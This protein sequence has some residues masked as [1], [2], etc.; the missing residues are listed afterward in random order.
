MVACG[1]PV[2]FC[3]GAAAFLTG[4]ATGIG[5][6]MLVQR[7]SS[8]IQL[9][10]LIAIPLFILAGGI[11]AR[12]GVAKRIVDF[13]YVLVG[14]FRGGLAMVN[15]IQSMFFGGVSGSAIADIS[16]TGPIMIPM[17]VQK[18]YDR[19][20]ST[21]ITVASA[22]QGIIIPPSHNMVIYAMVAGGVS[23]GKLFL[24]GYIPGIL[25]GFALMITCYYIA[26]KRGYPS[27]KRPPLRQSMVIVRDGLLAIMAA[28][29]IVG[30]IAFGIFTVSEAS[31]IAVFYAAFLGVVVYREMGLKDIWP[32][33]IDSVKTTSSV[34]FLIG[35]ASAFAW[36]MTFL[37][38]PANATTLLLS[39]T[40]NIYVLYIL[41]NFLL[42]ALG[43]I[44]DVAPL[45]VIVTPVLLPVMTATGMDPVTFGV[46]LMLNLGIGLTTPP[47]GTGLFVGCTVGGVTMEGTSRSMLALWPAMVIVLILVTYIP[48]LT[49]ALPNW[50][51]P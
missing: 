21:A 7:I 36:M 51:M 26:V 40:D 49:T 3:L 17:M 18:G 10:P 15:C 47:V 41:I 44:M 23:V 22:T 37:H 8:G 1:L 38:I 6:A 12:G 14:P 45:I 9:F 27:E 20:F 39:L 19:E 29:V 28:L 25:V 30:G 5:P 34:L 50:I 48:K 31:A 2:A 16:S 42:I 33:L 11:M 35:C 32:V 4:M 13:A 24:A 43:M 46:L